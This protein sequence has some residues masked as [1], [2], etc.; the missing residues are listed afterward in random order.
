VQAS[1]EVESLNSFFQMLSKDPDRA[2]Y[3]FPHVSKAHEAEAIDTLLLSDSLFR[4][5]GA[6]TW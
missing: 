2:F 3:G 5:V 4:C 6:S 1:K